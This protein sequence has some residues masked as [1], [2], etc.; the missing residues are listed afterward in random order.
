MPHRD[1][2]LDELNR[3]VGRLVEDRR[4]DH[5]AYTR[6]REVLSAMVVDLER[7]AEALLSVVERTKTRLAGITPSG[8]PAAGASPA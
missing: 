1:A 7:L 8:A 2:Q 6:E 3:L 5:E 4:A